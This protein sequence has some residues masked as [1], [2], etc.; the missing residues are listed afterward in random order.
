MWYVLCR[1]QYRC[2]WTPAIREP[3]PMQAYVLVLLVQNL[4][5][6]V[7]T[8]PTMHSQ[9][10]RSIPRI[11]DFRYREIRTY[12]PV[13]VLLAF[14]LILLR[15]RRPCRMSHGDALA[16]S[17]SAFA[18]QCGTSHRSRPNQTDQVQVLSH[19]VTSPEQVSTE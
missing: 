12:L 11:L 7:R 19:Y 3:T 18:S 16:T 4:L 17:P 10:S 13:T 15:F 2:Y 1:L 14:G 8:P 5:E 6:A 9:S